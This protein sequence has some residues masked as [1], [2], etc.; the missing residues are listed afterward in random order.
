MWHE[1]ASFFTQGLCPCL[2][3]RPAQ[4]SAMPNSVAAP[5]ASLQWGCAYKYGETLST[6]EKKRGSFRNKNCTRFKEGNN[7]VLK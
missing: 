1:Q 5:V 7:E 2:T 4:G 6:M 3:F